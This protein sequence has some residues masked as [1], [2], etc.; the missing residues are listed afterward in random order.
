MFAITCFTCFLELP[1]VKTRTVDDGPVAYCLTV[2]Y[3]SGMTLHG[4]DSDKFNVPAVG[5]RLESTRGIKLSPTT[6]TFSGEGNASGAS[7]IIAEFVLRIPLN[8]QVGSSLKSDGTHRDE[9]PTSTTGT[10]TPIT[11][12]K[13]VTMLIDESATVDILRRTSAGHVVN[14]RHP[15]ADR[16]KMAG[17]NPKMI[18]QKIP[19]S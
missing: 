18:H 6:D 2:S 19:D 9:S 1:L 15:E 10:G 11:S 17:P 8:S 5:I 16:S 3:T 14:K 13:L 7:G 4:T 12:R